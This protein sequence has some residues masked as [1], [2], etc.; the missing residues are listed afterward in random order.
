MRLGWWESGFSA[1]SRAFSVFIGGSF[2]YS[3]RFSVGNTTRASFIASLPFAWMTTMLRTRRFLPILTSA[4]IC[5]LALSGCGGKKAVTVK[6]KLVLPSNIKL[7]KTDVIQISFVPEDAKDTTRS[8]KPSPTDLSFVVQNASGK[9]LVPGKYKVTAKIDV[10]PGPDN[11]K[12]E[13]T[14]K[15][16]NQSYNLLKSKLI[17]EVTSDP[18]QTV[19]VD[20]TKGTVTKN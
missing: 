18:E 4:L 19:T 20:L 7:D 6:G 2:G 3:D 9:G 1:L 14:F 17:Y 10:Y 16:I 13:E 15:Q 11:K 5:L 8:A 12:R